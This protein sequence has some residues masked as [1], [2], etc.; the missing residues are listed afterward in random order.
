MY[1]H[2]RSHANQIPPVDCEK[3]NMKASGLFEPHSAITES[4]VSSSDEGPTSVT[5]RAHQRVG[6]P[7]R[8]IRLNASSIRRR[9]HLTKID[10]RRSPCNFIKQLL[11]K[12]NKKKSSR[13]RKKT[14]TPTPFERSE[15]EGEVIVHFE[16][17]SR[18]VNDWIAT[19]LNELEK[20]LEA[21]MNWGKLQEAGH[22]QPYPTE[23]DTI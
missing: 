18:I 3:V 4:L 16:I 2:T 9:N 22:D 1:R 8:G 11:E 12:I 19:R 23:R 7:T 15:K 20:H 21:L 17:A 10:N 13:Q 14:C 6:L 5:W